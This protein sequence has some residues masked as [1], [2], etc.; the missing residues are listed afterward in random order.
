MT[1]RKIKEPPYIKK[2]KESLIEREAYIKSLEKIKLADYDKL[3]STFRNFA[4]QSIKLRNTLEKLEFFAKQ[5]K[6]KEEIQKLNKL[7]HNQQ[8]EL[9]KWKSTIEKLKFDNKDIQNNLKKLT[10]SPR[11][12]KIFQE[13]LNQIQKTSKKEFELKE[14]VTYIYNYKTNESNI[15]KKFNILLSDIK[16]RKESEDLYKSYNDAKNHRESLLKILKEMEEEELYNDKTI[17]QI[18]LAKSLNRLF[19]NY[20]R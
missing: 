11:P 2:T 13:T 6:Y 19:K 18:N 14:L 5:N 10:D 1:T 3:S 12:S 17:E 8:E 7:I 4:D 20:D 15:S 9:S 16:K